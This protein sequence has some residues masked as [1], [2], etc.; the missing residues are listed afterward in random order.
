MIINSEPLSMAEALE[1]IKK[2]ADE[3]SKANLAEFIK[4]FTK[5]NPK[6]AKELREKIN[7]LG[8]IKLKKEYL[9]K[10]IDLLPE[11]APDLNKIFVDVTLEEDETKKIL[12][13]VKEFR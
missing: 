9:S 2:S 4:R 6:E 13:T 5:M 11:N 12:D 1:Y 7:E 8:L 3:D 10:I